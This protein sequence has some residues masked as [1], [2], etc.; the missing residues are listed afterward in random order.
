MDNLTFEECYK[1]LN[2]TSEA[3][4][5]D[6][7]ESYYKLVGEKLKT[8]NKQDLIDLK[9]AHSQLIQFY[10]NDQENQI[11]KEKKEYDN[12]LTKTINHQL[13]N[14]GIKIKVISY[15]Q[16]LQ[17]VINN[18]K[19]VKKE[20]LTKIIYDNLKHIL[21]DAE[22]AVII[23]NFDHKNNLIWEEKLKI[24]TGINAHKAQKYNTAILLAEAKINTNTYALPIA[25]LMAFVINF[26]EPLAWFISMGVHEF[27]HGT[28]AWFSGYRAMVTFAGTIISDDRSLFVY[29]GILTLLFLTFYS[30]WKE[31][32]KNTMIISV[33]LVIIQFILTWKTSYTNYQMLLYFGGI[34]GEFYLSTLL[35]ISFYWRLPDRFYWEFWR[36]IALIIGA[37][38]FWGSFTKW[39]R[40]SVG[41]E[42]IPWGTFWGGRGDSGG[43]LNVLNH[44]VGWSINQII[45]TYNTLG[46]ICL[47]I[48]TGIYLYFL[49]KSNPIFRLKFN[50]YFSINK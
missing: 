11:N 48:I 24:C 27:G 32:K 21:K 10:Q 49:W 36:F 23:S 3:T 12:Y 34:G 45:N 28:I 19:I 15:P 5:P 31:R 16:Y 41:K 26:V 43:D 46:F 47:L 6:I 7:E 42:Q 8:G 33:I 18:V 50:S 37:T 13:K 20:V 14:L 40:I 29:F 2:L 35:I 22:R 39:H 30:G 25:F 38:S 9:H 44:E 4:L 1:I 17:V